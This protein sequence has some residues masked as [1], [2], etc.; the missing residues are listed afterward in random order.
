MLPARLFANAELAATG[1]VRVIIPTVYRNNYLA[2]LVGVS[3]GAGDGQTLHSV[4]DFAQRWTS[5]ID[6]SSYEAANTE[7]RTANAYL[8][9]GVAEASGIRLRLPV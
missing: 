8:D 1:Q 5:L 7:L 2:G 6:W 9:S 4:L 3:N